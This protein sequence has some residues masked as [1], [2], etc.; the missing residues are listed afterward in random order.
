ML[1]AKS[2]VP[3]AAEWLS[4]WDNQAKKIQKGVTLFL[5]PPGYVL[6]DKLASDLKGTGENLCWHHLDREDNDPARLV[7]LILQSADRIYPNNGLETLKLMRRQPGPVFGWEPIYQVLAQELIGNLPESTSFVFD[8]VHLLS[9]ESA[10]LHLFCKQLLPLLAKYRRCILVSD[11]LIPHAILPECEVFGINDLRM[12]FGESFEV[13]RLTR[14]N[15]TRNTIENLVRIFEG[16]AEIIIGLIGLYDEFDNSFSERIFKD[17]KDPNQFL[18]R[19]IKEYLNSAGLDEMRSLALSS[20]LGYCHPDI[21]QS[22]LGIEAP[23][24]GPWFLHLTGQWEQVRKVWRKSLQLALKP[25]AA[26]MQWILPR[27]AGSLL[28]LHAVDEA[29]E[30][31]LSINKYDHAAAL[32]EKRIEEMFNIGQ[33]ITIQHWLNRLPAWALASYPLLIYFQGELAA[34]RKQTRVARQYFEKATRLFHAQKEPAKVCK[35]VLAE[36]TIAIWDNDFFKAQQ[37]AETAFQIAEQEGLQWYQGVVNWQ[38]G[39]LSFQAGNVEKAAEHFKDAKNIFPDGV[40]KETFGKAE[41]ISNKIVD[42]KQQGE[43]HRLAYLQA[44]HAER[45]AID[46]L[47]SILCSPNSLS[48][49]LIE[50]F[51]W[52]KTPLFIKL[53]LKSMSPFTPTNNGKHL[54]TKVLERIGFIRHPQTETALWVPQIQ[55]GYEQIQAGEVKPSDGIVEPEQTLSLEKDNFPTCLNVS[56]LG[57]FQLSIDKTHLQIN[58]ARAE[59]VLKYLLMHHTQNISR[60]VLM[61]MFWPEAIP[62][63]ARNNLNVAIHHLR[64]SFQSVTSTPI[65]LFD[66]NV[67]RINPETKVYLDIDAFENHLLAGQQLEARGNTQSAVTEFET[68]I[69]LYQGDFL[70]DDP[71]E[72]WA[73]PVREKLR[74]AYLDLLNHLSHIYF[75]QGKLAACVALCQLTLERDNCREDAHCLL[76]HCYCQQG[77]DYLALRQYQA[78]VNALK[79]EL[80]VEPSQATR[81]LAERIRHHEQV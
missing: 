57:N 76:M 41:I 78:C 52:A 55:P 11:E 67:Y 31:L 46:A 27:V 63:A 65:I 53:P 29:V 12:E 1:A 24:I 71:Y 80:E 3:Y 13:A 18:T 77:Q 62:E 33:W 44:K 61:D 68:V 17:T 81:E 30:I 14:A 6:S 38:L 8:Q 66:R 23:M 25:D 49:L 22:V 48:P 4:N 34:M 74:I 19:T 56:L 10:T 7:Q 5:V 43:S 47:H 9:S 2:A 69:A 15:L 21:L 64:Q 51:G 36:S 54:L 39:C 75:S 73:V 28:D 16:R 32:I 40:S 20:H 45:S 59:N 70:Q 42:A 50:T 72:D 60:E 58:G 79:N 26:A 35:S 37:K